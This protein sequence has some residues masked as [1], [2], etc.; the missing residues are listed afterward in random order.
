MFI[1]LKKLKT[2]EALLDNYN[3]KLN[4]IENKINNLSIKIEE[5][6]AKINALNKVDNAPKQDT[7]NNFNEDLEKSSIYIYF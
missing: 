1:V 3:K 2:L 5:L 7:G 6:E 4:E